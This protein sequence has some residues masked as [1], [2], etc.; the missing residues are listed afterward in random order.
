MV[1]RVFQKSSSMKIMNT[2]QESI[3]SPCDTNSVPPELEDIDFPN[4]NTSFIDSNNN[5][6]TSILPHQ[7][8]SSVDN[9]SNNLLGNLNENNLTWEAAR[10][11]AAA[12]PP[13]LPWPSSFLSSTNLAMNSL[14][15]KVLQL[16]SIAATNS[17][18]YGHHHQHQQHSLLQPQV[19]VP[20]AHQ[21]GVGTDLEASFNVASSSSKQQ[22]GVDQQQQQ[23][24]SLSWASFNEGL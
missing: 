7:A 24:Q 2:Q 16:K 14:I 3:D 9:N 8:P 12:P 18:D 10:S 19:A 13:Q 15:L 6:N 1:C 22:Q 21:L 11:L 20:P 5:I 23:E 4:L 17:S